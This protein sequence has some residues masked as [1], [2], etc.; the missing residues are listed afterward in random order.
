VTY[1]ECGRRQVARGLVLGLSALALLACSP[2]VRT[3]G[4]RFDEVALDQ[5]RPGS[6]TRDQVAALLGSPSTRA[7]LDDSIWYYISQTSERA[8]FY[9]N[10]VVAQDVV[11]ITFDDIGLVEEVARHNLADATEIAFVERETPTS[12]NE[13]SIWEQFVGNIGRFNP[14][15]GEDGP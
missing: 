15:P 8:T 2:N 7:P 6:T 4:Y 3:H 10:E 1:L 14:Q 5:V 11:A 13:L 9:Q 12:G